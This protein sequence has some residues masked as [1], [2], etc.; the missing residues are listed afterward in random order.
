M[1]TP[2][3][4]GKGYDDVHQ[5]RFELSLSQIKYN[6]ETGSHILELGGGGKFTDMLRAE[7][8][9]V[10]I[11]FDDYRYAEF[12]GAYDAVIA[13]EIVEHLHDQEANIPTEW[14]GTGLDH[15]LAQCKRATK[16]G[17]WFFCT[18][19]NADSLNVINK[20]IHRQAPMVYR[21]HVREYTVHELVGAVRKANFEVTH[22]ETYEC[23]DN[24]MSPHMRAVITRMLM[25]QLGPHGL[26][27]RGEDIFLWAR[28]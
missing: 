4:A 23:W 27:H 1:N 17:G 22:V 8:Y 15:T 14:R 3:Y 13:M 28:A 11:P 19:P 25:D 7:G 16:P 2:N 6:V 20:V 9:K 24:S 5:K 10:S 26:D 21:P 12:T 18:T